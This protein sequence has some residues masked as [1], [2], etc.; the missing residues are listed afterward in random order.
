MGALSGWLALLACL[1]ATPAHAETTVAS[2]R[3]AGVLHCGID[4]SEA[5]YSLTDEHGPR[6]LFDQDICKAV[7]IA[8]LG[9][10][11]K[12]EFKTFP[13]D[14]TSLEA[15]RA[16]SVDMIASVSLDL[17]HATT[18]GVSYTRPILHDGQALMVP[19][20]DH[21]ESP[22][23][24][25]HRTVCFLDGTEGSD[26]VRAWFQQRHIDIWPYPFQEQGE[27]EA[28][29]V[30]GNCAVL[31]GDW[32]RLAAVR[33]SFGARAAQYTMLPEVL[34]KDPLG[35]AYRRRDAEFGRV[36][37][38]ALEALLQAEE[39]GINSANVDAMKASTDPTIRRLLGASH[40]TG[41]LLGLSQDWAAD[42]IVTLG[43]YGEIF[44]RDLG[45]PLKVARGK[46][47]LAKDG[48]LMEALPM[49]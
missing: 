30:T 33:A 46:N 18:G 36:I 34:S 47:A 20:K 28:V 21:L 48:G 45:I 39:S 12:V 3:S 8:L 44:Q 49:P 27:M 43:N 14:Q 22:D 1:L 5:E 16:G 2:I 37:V 41:N 38:W 9:R 42:V 4:R 40:E 35:A 26:Q 15:L 29:F 24:L 19:L 6:L 10:T 31:A 17:S 7:A 13:D 11:A 25:T 23:K 32:T